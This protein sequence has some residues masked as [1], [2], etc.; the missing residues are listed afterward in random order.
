MA[1]MAAMGFL[2]KCHGIKLHPISCHGR[3]G[4]A[5]ASHGTGGWHGPDCQ[6]F[7]GVADRKDVEQALELWSF[8]A[9]NPMNHGS[10]S[11]QDLRLGQIGQR[12]MVQI[13]EF[14]QGSE[15]LSGTFVYF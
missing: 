8:G 15:V 9:G 5:F 3:H 10:V 6:T 2:G 13:F 11:C 12:P 4:Q 7:C 1:A 14:L